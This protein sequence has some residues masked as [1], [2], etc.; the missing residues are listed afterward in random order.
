MSLLALAAAQKYI[1]DRLEN[2]NVPSIT[3][4]YTA[5]LPAAFGRFALPHPKI[6][7]TREIRCSL[8]PSLSLMFPGTIAWFLTHKPRPWRV[9]V[10]AEKSSYDGCSSSNVHLPTAK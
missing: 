1:G 9:T 10:E 7:E 5:D 4:R 6:A 3:G 8:F 2:N